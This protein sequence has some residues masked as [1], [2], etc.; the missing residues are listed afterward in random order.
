VPADLAYGLGGA[1]SAQHVLLV[2]TAPP[3][4]VHRSTEDFVLQRVPQSK[5]V[6]QVTV[7]FAAQIPEVQVSVGI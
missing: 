7:G 3:A 6:T 2:P 4:A 5:S 1:Q